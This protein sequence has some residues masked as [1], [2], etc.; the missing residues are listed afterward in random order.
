MAKKRC[1]AC[2]NLA[3]GGKAKTGLCA[4]C[5][6]V[7][8]S[9]ER[10]KDPHTGLKVNGDQGVY[11]TRTTERI[12]TLADLVRVCDIDT[13]EWEIKEWVANKWDQG[14]VHRKTGDIQIAELFQIKVWLRRRVEVQDAKRAIAELMEQAKT[15]IKSL[16]RAPRL[17]VE[18]LGPSPYML[19]LSVYDHHFGKLAWGQETGHES[20]DLKI[21]EKLFRRA[22]TALIERTRGFT[23]GKVLFVVG[24][25]ILNA[26]NKQNTTTRGTPQSV[27][28]RYHK[29]FSVVQRVLIDTV[30]LLR[31]IA[32]EV[33][34]VIVPGNHDEV[35]AWHL[36]N[37]LDT[38]FHNVPGV[39]VDNAPTMRK[40]VRHGNN[41]IMITHGDKGKKADYPQVMAHEQPVAW[42]ETTN[43]EVHVGHIHQTRVQEFFGVRVRTLPAL[44]PPD[45]WHSEN[46]YVGNRR[47]AEAFVWHDVEGIVGTA[48][49]TLQPGAVA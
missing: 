24:Q 5:S 4:A 28:G 34:V 32:P 46:H 17:R 13:E 11:T 10:S 42:G 3:A 16:V 9:T 6:R 7:R 1:L 36:G 21:A 35:A 38:Y 47:A 27:D 33:L 45:A 37:S 15:S 26:D 18:Q 23:F 30:E 20:Y 43:R 19:E 25:D 48:I 40:Y 14:S 49:H 29:S 41:L 39:T 31:T 12:K 22:V 8:Q 2:P 44:C